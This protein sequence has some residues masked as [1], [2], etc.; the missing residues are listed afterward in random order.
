MEK[1]RGCCRGLWISVGHLNLQSCAACKLFFF[2]WKSL[3]A[4]RKGLVKRRASGRLFLGV[5]AVAFRGPY[6]PG[7]GYDPRDKRLL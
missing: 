3:F 5:V 1:G 7:T 4:T 2:R 6:G